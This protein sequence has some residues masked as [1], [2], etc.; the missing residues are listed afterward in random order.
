[1]TTTGSSALTPAA[2]LRVALELFDTGVELM[3]QRLRRERPE[4][5]EDEVSHALT[6]WLHQRPGA[7]YG[8][9]VGRPRPLP[10]TND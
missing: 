3:R 8:D 7:E 5:T 4:A 6:E 9:T 10:E 1:M 2:R